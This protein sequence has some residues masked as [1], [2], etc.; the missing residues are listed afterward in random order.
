MIV[1]ERIYDRGWH[2]GIVAKLVT[3]EDGDNQIEIDRMLVAINKGRQRIR[4]VVI[5]SDPLEFL[6]WDMVNKLTT[7]LSRRYFTIVETEHGPKG[8]LLNAYTMVV[9]KP[10]YFINSGFFNELL[11]FEREELNLRK[12]CSRFQELECQP[13]KVLMVDAYTF[14]DSLQRCRELVSEYPEFVLRL[15]WRLER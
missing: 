5:T 1:Q 9:P 10:P 4:N 11:L 15:P 13:I 7:K 3:F 6:P 14:N 8:Q 2:Q 12:I